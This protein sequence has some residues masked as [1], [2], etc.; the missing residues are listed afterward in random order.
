MLDDNPADAV[1]QHDQTSVDGVHVRSLTGVTQQQSQG[2]STLLS[3]K[4][5]AVHSRDAGLQHSVLTWREKKLP[6]RLDGE[7]HGLKGVQKSPPHVVNVSGATVRVLVV[8]VVDDGR[9]CILVRKR[10]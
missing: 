6:A 8:G 3:I 2:L 5:G 9:R 4:P 1:F 10:V 7:P